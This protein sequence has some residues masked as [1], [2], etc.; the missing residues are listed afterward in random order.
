ME[1]L[2]V[3]DDVTISKN[4]KDAFEAD[5]WNV[6]CVYD[7][8]L[9]QRLLEKEQ[10]DC[11]VLDINLPSVTGY[12]LCENF[13]RHNTVTPVI[14]LTA[15][16]ELEDKIKGFDCGADD[17]LT[18]PFYMKE[19]TLRVNSLFKRSKANHQLGNIE[20]EIVSKDIVLDLKQK[21][22]TK[23]GVLMDLTPREFQILKRLLTHKGEVVTKS[24]LITEIW[25]K[26]VD[27]NTNTIEVYINFLR[28]K[29]GK[30]TIKTKVGY[31]YYISE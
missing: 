24:E 28:N 30:E 2:V 14:M 10:F 3:E 26:S 7:G 29:L 12:K 9:A 20:K 23:D 22:V 31:G 25:G 19:L 18:K 21:T 4:I 13:K 5:G 11:V 16:G 17:Y 1:L 27:A 15:F 6:T 8:Q